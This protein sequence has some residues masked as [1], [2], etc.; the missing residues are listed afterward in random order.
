MTASFEMHSPGKRLHFQTFGESICDEVVHVLCTRGFFLIVF[1]VG[2]ILAAGKDTPGKRP[3][4]SSP[5]A[6]THPPRP[7]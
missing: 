6:P 4:D 3:G 5:I 7:P 1:V 2:P